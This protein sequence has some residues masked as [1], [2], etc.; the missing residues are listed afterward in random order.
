[1]HDCYSNADTDLYGKLHS[2]SYKRAD[3]NSQLIHL[4]PSSFKICCYSFFVVCA[5]GLESRTVALP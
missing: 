5:P 1:M 2:S 4:E 3:V